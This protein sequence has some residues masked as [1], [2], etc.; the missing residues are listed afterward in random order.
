MKNVLCIQRSKLFPRESL[1]LTLAN[2]PAR[3]PIRISPGGANQN[4]FCTTGAL[5]IAEAQLV[6]TTG[7]KLQETTAY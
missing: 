5:V 6:R 2:V 4:W 7:L 1:D 3:P